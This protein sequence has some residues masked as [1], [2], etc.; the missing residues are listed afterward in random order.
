M[1]TKR[2]SIS[3]LFIRIV[4]IIFAVVSIFPVLFAV[5]TSFK[6][7]QEFY[8]NIWALPEKIGTENYITAIVEGRI[9]EY[10]I[11]SIIISAVTLFMVLILGIMAAYAL[12]RIN[13]PGASVMLVFLILIQILPTESLVIPEYMIVSRLG[14]LRT[15]YWAMILPYV[16]WMLPGTIIILANFFKTIPMELIEA[17]RIDGAS[18][19]KTMTRIIAPL[20]KSSIATCLVFNF[21]FVWGELM[22]AQ[23]ATL[24]KEDG[25]PLTIGLLNFKG[26]YSTNWGAT[27]AAICII[28]IPLYVLFL[29]TQKYFIAGLT[30]GGVKG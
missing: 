18:E 14:L 9:G 4:L 2:F 22:W 12:S 8:R 10:A 3:L 23:I 25:I 16:G 11:N 28:T 21:C 15:R 30:A 29:F 26:L 24:V 20:M 27:A 17:A 13:I 19:F 1:S 5:L 6:T 7:N